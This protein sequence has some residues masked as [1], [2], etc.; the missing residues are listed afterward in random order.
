MVQSRGS[1]TLLR[2]YQ[3]AD[4][5]NAFPRTSYLWWLQPQ[6]PPFTILPGEIGTYS[7]NY[8]RGDLKWATLCRHQVAKKETIVGSWDLN[9]W[10]I[11]RPSTPT[12]TAGW[13]TYEFPPDITSLSWMSSIPQVASLEWKDLVAHWAREYR[14]RP[15]E[16]ELE[17]LSLCVKVHFSVN[18]VQRNSSVDYDKIYYHRHPSARSDPISYWGYLSTNND[19]EAQCDNLER[20]G[21]EF[22]YH[23]SCD[24]LDIADD[25]G[26]KYRKLLGESLSGIP[27]SFPGLLYSGD[28]E[29]DE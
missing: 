5:A 28:S 12:I 14:T 25:W 9:R 27:G 23:L 21:W 4:R 19:P 17:S 22:E 6:P 18:V 2:L 26:Y 16:V 11:F 24:K 1:F 8:Y 29:F 7:G 15:R 3:L 13:L 10:Q 20:Q